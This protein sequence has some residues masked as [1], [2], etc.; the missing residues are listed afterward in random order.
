VSDQPLLLDDQHAMPT[1]VRERGITRLD[2]ILTTMQETDAL[3][4]EVFPRLRS[5]RRLTPAEREH[6]SRRLAGVIGRCE[7]IRIWLGAGAPQ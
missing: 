4:A 6:L 5:T 7:G 3:I 2:L 1:T